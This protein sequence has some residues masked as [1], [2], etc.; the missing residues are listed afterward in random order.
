MIV[1]RAGKKGFPQPGKKAAALVASLLLASML[2]MAGCASEASSEASSS[3]QSSSS[4]SS[5]AEAAQSMSVGIVVVDPKDD[6]LKSL[7]ETVSAEEGATVLDVLEASTADADIEDSSYGK[8]VTGIGGIDAEGS[9]GWVYTVNGE[10]VME[11][12]DSCVLA[13]GDTVEFKYITM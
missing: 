8:Y 7:D 12:I 9:S 11:S 13:D 5:S 1:S 2:A 10:E 3:S 6:A 4:Q